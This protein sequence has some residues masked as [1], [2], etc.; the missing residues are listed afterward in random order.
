MTI[1]GNFSGR[2]FFHLIL[3]SM[4]QLVSLHR[5][6]HFGSDGPFF[7]LCDNLDTI[8]RPFFLANVHKSNVFGISSRLAD[9]ISVNALAARRSF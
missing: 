8:F 5:L 1:V 6:R 7:L 9:F 4:L 3:F 2:K